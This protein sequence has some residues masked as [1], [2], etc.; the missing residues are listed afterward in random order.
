MKKEVTIDD[1]KN[2]V[3][4]LPYFLRKIF[5]KTYRNQGL[6]YMD[7]NN[8]SLLPSSTVK[9]LEE[10]IVITTSQKRANK[11]LFKYFNETYP[12]YKNYVQLF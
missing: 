8:P 1:T 12:E 9:W 2:R 6:M 5:L 3:R 11:I 7:G 10:I 4:H